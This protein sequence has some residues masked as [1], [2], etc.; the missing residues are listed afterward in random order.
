MLRQKRIVTKEN[1]YKIF[2]LSTDIDEYYEILIK[3]N[4]TIEKDIY[5]RRDSN[6]RPLD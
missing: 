3:F 1:V 6:P 5:P 2:V 4:F